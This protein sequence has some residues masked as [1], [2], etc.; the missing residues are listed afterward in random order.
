MEPLDVSVEVTA[1]IWRV[2]QN[3][4]RLERFPVFFPSVKEAR[5][6]SKNRLF[7]RE[8]HG[9]GE[10]SSTFE[11]NFLPSEN[12]LTWRSLSGP[13][14]TG[15]ALCN[16]LPGGVTRLTLRVWYIPDQM[17][18]ADAESIVERHRA[19]LLAFKRFVEGRA[20]EVFASSGGTGGLLG[21]GKLQRG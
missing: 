2:Y 17:S 15:R 18:R 12:G 6:I 19:Y 3:W 10:Y 9:G 8:E 14:N 5:W 21:A 4:L 13:P 20:N 16:A 1:P 7:W 11:I